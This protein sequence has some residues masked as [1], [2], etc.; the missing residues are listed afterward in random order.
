MGSLAK[1]VV[2]DPPPGKGAFRARYL[3]RFQVGAGRGALQL[4]SAAAREG[5]A[6]AHNVK[7][8]RIAAP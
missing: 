5:G 4:R 8:R 7:G 6:L 2:F 1:W 3:F